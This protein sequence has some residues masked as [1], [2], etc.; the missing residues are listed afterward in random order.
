M[1]A[2]VAICISSHQ[3][4][5]LNKCMCNSTVPAL[6]LYFQ[7]LMCPYFVDST[8]NNVNDESLTG[9][10]A[11]LFRHTSFILSTDWFTES[12]VLFQRKSTSTIA[13]TEWEIY[14][15]GMLF[16]REEQIVAIKALGWWHQT[17]ILNTTAST[18]WPS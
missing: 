9:L 15:K 7:L 17:P 5:L 12:T 2:Q 16:A 6:L 3:V 14:I 13:T 8:A 18:I 4:P 1:A 11:N 10:N